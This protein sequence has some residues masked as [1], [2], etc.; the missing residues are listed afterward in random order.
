MLYD[1]FFFISYNGYDVKPDGAVYA[2]LLYVG[3]GR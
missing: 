2:K 3:I 1:V